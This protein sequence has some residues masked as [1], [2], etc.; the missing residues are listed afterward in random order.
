MKFRR[1][2][3]L[4][5][6]NEQWI[7]KLKE[8]NGNLI[9]IGGPKGSGKTTISEKLGYPI[10]RSLTTRDKRKTYE[11]YD[12]ITPEEFHKIESK[13]DF[14]SVVGYKDRRYGFTIEHFES[15]AKE[16][17]TI[18]LVSCPTSYRLIKK[19]Y[20][21][22]I[23]LFVTAPSETVMNR[24]LSR[25]GFLDKVRVRSYEL[26]HRSLSEYNI[27]LKNTFHPTVITI[28]AKMNIFHWKCKMFFRQK[29]GIVANKN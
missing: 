19:R 2:G 27:V 15:L 23:G 18:V 10:I 17:N 29:V 26:N 12:F 14:A 3:N 25:D 24:L 6:I 28:K 16:S 1:N 21:K 4:Y 13:N 22:T 20:S 5:K 7:E 11:T 9:V 8:W